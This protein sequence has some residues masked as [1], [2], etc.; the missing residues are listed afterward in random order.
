MPFSRYPK[1]QIGIR[2]SRLGVDILN[3][4]GPAC[5]CCD[6]V[7]CRSQHMKTIW[8]TC[9]PFSSGQN[10]AFNTLF[11]VVLSLILL[12]GTLLNITDVVCLVSQFTLYAKMKKG[13]AGS[14]AAAS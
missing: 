5:V 3:W 7:N 4:Q 2:H 1:S 6:D 9:T 13:R 8:L 12:T 14:G 11:Y 10:L